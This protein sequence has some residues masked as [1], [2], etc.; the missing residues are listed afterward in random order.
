MRS[1]FLCHNEPKEANCVLHR[2]RPQYAKCRPYMWLGSWIG[3][4]LLSV[5]FLNEVSIVGRDCKSIPETSLKSRTH[6]LYEIHTEATGRA[7][8]KATS[9]TVAQRGKYL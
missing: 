2:N 5:G 6:R 4:S 9:P 7:T 8:G 3:G 1:T